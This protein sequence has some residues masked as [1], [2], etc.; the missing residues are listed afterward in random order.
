MCR[1]TPER[2]QEIKEQMENMTFCD[3][4]Y[5]SRTAP[6][7]QERR[8]Y[9]KEVNKILKEYEKANGDYYGPIIAICLSI[10]SLIVAITTLILKNFVL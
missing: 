5:A 6:T 9:R 10:F 8:I 2:A 7:R 4:D 3:I 1:L